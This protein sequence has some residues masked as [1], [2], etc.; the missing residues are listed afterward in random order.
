MYVHIIDPE[1]K[2]RLLCG[3]IRHDGRSY[4]PL[5]LY[6]SGHVKPAGNTQWCPFCMAA[7]GAIPAVN[8]DDEETKP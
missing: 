4:L 2:G 8:V 3:V 5:D 1:D 6:L 7:S